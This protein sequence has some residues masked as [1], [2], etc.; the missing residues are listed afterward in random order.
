MKINLP[1]GKEKLTLDLPD[2]AKIDVLET[3]GIRQP[4]SEQE[5]DS[6]LENPVGQQKLEELVDKGDQIVIIACD[7]ARPT[8]NELLID[9]VISRLSQVPIPDKNI[10]IVFA[11]GTHPQ[12]NEKEMRALIGKYY[13][14]FQ[15]YQHEVD[16]NT[17][18]LGKT[19]R[20]TE[21]NINNRVLEAD[22]KIGLAD[23]A[24]HP[25]AGYGGGTKVILPGVS[26]R[27]SINHNHQMMTLPNVKF[28]GVTKGNPIR[29]DMNEAAKI[30]SMDYIVNAI[31]GKKLETLGLVAGDPIKAF[32]AGVEIAK[33]V[34][35]RP[36]PEE[37]DVVIATSFP[38]D[39]NFYQ[40]S[41]G[42]DN[43]RV[44]VRP[45]GKIIL[46]TPSYE[47]VGRE[48]FAYYST[49]GEAELKEILL[50]GT[51]RDLIEVLVA[52][53]DINR[54]REKADIHIVSKGLKRETVESWRMAYH[55]SP[56]EAIRKVIEPGDSVLVLPEG[57]F[58][59]P[60][61]KE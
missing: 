29:E 35:E 15:I 54:T 39:L 59:L 32:D 44:A 42:F 61:L 26:N 22:I 10:S 31:L 43:A 20:G 3:A 48:D 21:V 56:K 41:K 16:T 30:A 52:Y 13:N 55:D 28:L 6:I 58:T 2:T 36:I 45:R 53:D 18:I 60:V 8:P 23:V 1:Y 5:V 50:S 4:L 19:K 27:R 17:T 11:L 12:M 34:Y 37:Y 25:W 38:M 46:F 49:L 40:G 47:G 57:A 14:R 7:K 51:A 24:P 9:F 33:T